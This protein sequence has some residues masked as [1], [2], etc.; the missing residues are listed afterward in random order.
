MYLNYSE[1]VWI[2]SFL[3]AKVKSKKTNGLQKKDT[4]KTYPIFKNLNYPEQV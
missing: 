1:K 3:I 2:C 4:R